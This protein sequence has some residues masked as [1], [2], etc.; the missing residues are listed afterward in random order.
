MGFTVV[1]V[2]DITD[3][4]VTGIIVVLDCSVIV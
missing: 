2:S 3:V 4:F 1:V